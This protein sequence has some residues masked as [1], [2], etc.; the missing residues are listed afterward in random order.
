VPEP[1]KPRLLVLNQYYWPGVEATAQ[2]LTELCEA[3]AE[4]AEVKVVTGVLHGHEDEPRRVV[5]QGVEIVRVPSTSF[6]RSKFFARASNYVTYLTNA[7][8]RGIRGP[9]PDVVICMTDPPI[10]ADVALLVARRYRTPLVVISQD[11]FPEI[12]VQLK[13]LENP[14]LMSLLRVLVRIYLRRADRLVAIGETMRKRLE[15]KGAPPDRVRVIP[16][17]VDTKRLA[18]LGKDNDW[19][20]GMGFTDKF[21]VMH[22]GNVGHAQDLDSLVRAATFLRDLD[23]LVVA[24]IGTGA[25]HAELVA[26]AQLLEVDRVAFLYYQSRHVLPQSLSAADV[27]VVGLAP[28]LAGYV[29]PSRLYGILAVARPVI[30]AADDDSETAQ[31][32]QQI[33]CGIVVPPGRP[34]LLARAIRDTH[35]GRYDLE[36]MGRLGREWVTAEADRNVAVGRYRELLLE[37]ADI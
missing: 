1:R 25:R 22:S 19:A 33:G 23:D 9:R 17:W 12:A 31:V 16:N 8:V 2:L 20:R 18:P 32:V 35:D 5:H 15:E 10:V 4:A 36:R 37:L 27:H 30:V 26:L 28:G 21:V 34:E 7:F 29:V 13:R 3:L 6:E 24:I 11:V 14:A